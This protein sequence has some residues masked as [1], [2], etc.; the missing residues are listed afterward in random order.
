MLVIP[1]NIVGPDTVNHATTGQPLFHTHLMKTIYTF[2]YVTYLYID[3]SQHDVTVIEVVVGSGSGCGVD[4]SRWWRGGVMVMGVVV[5]G[6]KELS[7]C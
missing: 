5:S 3:V 4:T 6:A 2:T 1:L 7:T